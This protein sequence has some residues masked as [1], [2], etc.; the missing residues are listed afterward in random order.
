MDKQ[1]SRWAI[2][3]LLCAALAAALLAGCAA[4]PRQH[5]AASEPTVELA[6]AAGLID[7]LR[8]EPAVRDAAIWDNPYGEGLTI[9][10]AHYRIYTTHLEPLMLRQVPAFLES[11]FRAYQRQL[12]APLSSPEPFVVYLFGTRDQWEH[13]TRDTAGTDA[14]VYLQI[15]AGAY[16]ADGVC[17]AYNIGRRQTFAILGHEG[18]HQF[19]QRLFVYRLP[20]WL[21]EG[22]A[23]L[24]ETCRYEQGRFVFEPASN[25]MRLGSLKQA[26][27]HNRLMPLEELL[28]LNPGQLLT[29]IN[30]NSDRASI[31][32]AQVYA[33][34][35]FLREAG[36]GTRLRAYEA[37]L[38]DA[39]AGNWPL[40]ERLL[41][42]AADRSVPLTV[43]WNRQASRA[44][45]SHYFGDNM[46]SLN[47]EYRVFC[48]KITYPVRIRPR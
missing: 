33:L 41:R 5:T 17:V 31:F 8:S 46:A 26:L 15:Q 24:F 28:L 44:L 10:T 16:V 38:H 29:D 48:S 32:Y 23:T 21:D 9:D 39:A 4:A 11:A 1:K 37:L 6:T 18:W 3:R 20:S 34:V 43:S 42:I 45:F 40:D 13:Y 30:G 25:L 35:R 14:D 47:A 19:N 36:Y 27:M 22:I 7:Y 2:Y 12:P